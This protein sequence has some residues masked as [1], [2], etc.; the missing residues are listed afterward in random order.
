[1]N[2]IIEKYIV[3]FIALAV[4]AGL[5]FNSFFAT[6]VPLVS[7]LLGIVMFGI[8][9]NLNGANFKPVWDIKGKTII[10][11]ALK[12]IFVSIG[13][14]ILSKVFNLNAMETAGLVILGSC[15]GGTVANIYSFLTRSNLALTVTLT[16]LSTLI[17]PIAIPAL[18][19]LYLHKTIH[20]PYFGMFIKTLEIVIL[21]I[22]VGIFK[23]IYFRH[24]PSKKSI[25]IYLNYMRLL[26]CRY[27][28]RDK[29]T[30]GNRISSHYHINLLS[31]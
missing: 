26:N 20:I 29:S 2:N 19:Y 17:A 16:I 23:Q 7:Y 11:V 1:M 3:V 22:V 31:T 9:I 10:I 6:L 8:G 4:T 30:Q 13:A 28:C 5:V 14:F 24:Q 25:A 18:L 15:P 12:F 21:P 27:C